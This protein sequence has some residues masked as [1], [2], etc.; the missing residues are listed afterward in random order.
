[1]QESSRDF[2]PDLAREFEYLLGHMPRVDRETFQGLLIENSEASER[3]L[4]AENELFDAYLRGDL[5]GEWRPAFEQR[6]LETRRGVEKLAAARKLQQKTRRPRRYLWLSSAIAAGIALMAGF[7]PAIST[8]NRGGG[9]ESDRKSS[10]R[11]N[12]PVA[13][14]AMQ[15]QQL[16]LKPITRGGSAGTSVRA[17]FTVDPASTTHLALSLPENATSVELS[18]LGGPGGD[19]VVW[20]STGPPPFRVPIEL[21][22][23]GAYL[24]SSFLKGQPSNFYEFE[25]VRK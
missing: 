10:T 9:N 18:I 7:W 5:P 16:D 12:T 25:I 17:R 13:V 2:R 21:V 20:K 11:S 6:F 15:I 23:A 22:P 3:V 4:E 19:R 24:V 1:M 14:T 8:W